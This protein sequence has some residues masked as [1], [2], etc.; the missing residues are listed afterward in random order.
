[1]NTRVTEH[2]LAEYPI[3]PAAAAIGHVLSWFTPVAVVERNVRWCVSASA[4]SLESKER[5]L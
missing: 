5:R 3:A 4:D 1:M 2:L